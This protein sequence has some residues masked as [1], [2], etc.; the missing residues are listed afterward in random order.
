[1][2]GLRNLALRRHDEFA[3]PIDEAPGE[4]GGLIDLHRRQALQREVTSLLKGRWNHPSARP[5]DEPGLAE[6]LG[7]RQPT[8]EFASQPI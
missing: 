7:W 1:M 3:G 2:K 8:V 6:L 5:I 4:P